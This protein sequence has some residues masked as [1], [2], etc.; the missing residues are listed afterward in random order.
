[1]IAQIELEHRAWV[2][3]DPQ[4]RRFGPDSFFVASERVFEQSLLILAAAGVDT[5]E[6]S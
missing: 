6:R 1:V 2:A 4:N 3:E 5:K